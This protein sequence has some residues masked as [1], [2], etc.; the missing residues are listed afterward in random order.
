MDDLS[1][2]VHALAKWKELIILMNGG[3]GTRNG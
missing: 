2:L 1:N 3:A